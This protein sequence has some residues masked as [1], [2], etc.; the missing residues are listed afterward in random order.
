MSVCVCAC[1]HARLFRLDCTYVCVHTSGG[2]LERETGEGEEKLVHS[3]ENSENLPP[4]CSGVL[5]R[6]RSRAPVS[7]AR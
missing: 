1:V 6:G 7:H 3:A 5:V 4:P 2:Q